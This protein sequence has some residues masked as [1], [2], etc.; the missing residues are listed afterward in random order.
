MRD[1][2]HHHHHGHCGG[3][4]QK[5]Y[6]KTDLWANVLPIDGA[7]TDKQRYEKLGWAMY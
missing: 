7:H 2:H 6:F 1:D 3:N 5:F 4:N